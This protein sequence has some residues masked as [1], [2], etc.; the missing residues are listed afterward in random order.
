MIPSISTATLL[1]PC[2]RTDKVGGRAEREGKG[3][4][5]GRVVFDFEEWRVKSGVLP[6]HLGEGGVS[7]EI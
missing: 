1:P 6:V 7:E 3:R 4:R 2:W 5:E